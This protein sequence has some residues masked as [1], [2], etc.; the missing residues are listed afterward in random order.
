MD[1]I[2]RKLALVVT[3][4]NSTEKA[5]TFYS[6]GMVHILTFIPFYIVKYCEKACINLDI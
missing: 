2:F 3:P 4:S 6:A 5:Y 1:A